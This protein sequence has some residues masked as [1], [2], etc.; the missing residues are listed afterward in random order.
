MSHK[1][2]YGWLFPEKFLEENKTV[3]IKHYLLYN[4]IKLIIPTEV[5]VWTL[6]IRPGF[7]FIRMN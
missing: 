6:D 5:S 3:S 4:I 7:H 2:V 1:I